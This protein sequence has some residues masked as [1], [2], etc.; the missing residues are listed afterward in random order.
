[1]PK[2]CMSCEKAEM[3]ETCTILKKTKKGKLKW[4]TPTRLALKRRKIVVCGVCWRS[5]TWEA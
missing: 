5:I 1:M 2:W 3:P 4:I